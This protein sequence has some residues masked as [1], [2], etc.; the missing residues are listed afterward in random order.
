M[1]GRGDDGAPPGPPAAAVAP[2]QA[3]RAAAPG[4][5]AG[6]MRRWAPP[7]PHNNQQAKGVQA[8]G[9]VSSHACKWCFVG[10]LWVLVLVPRP[11]L[12]VRVLP[13]QGGGGAELVGV[14]APLQGLVPPLQVGDIDIEPPLAPAARGASRRAGRRA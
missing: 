4:K 14:Q 2:P 13:L 11:R 3:L 9:L 1:T 10:A 12:L 8:T 7:A 6:R 5:P